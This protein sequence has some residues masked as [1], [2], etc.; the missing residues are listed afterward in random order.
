M[1]LLLKNVAKLFEDSNKAV[2]DEAQ[3]LGVEIYRWIGEAMKPSLDGLRPAQVK[4]L[5]E[6]FAKLPKGKDS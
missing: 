2:R 3:T 1:K 5:E 6:A 4:E